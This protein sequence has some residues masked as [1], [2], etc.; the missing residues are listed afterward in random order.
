MSDP[1][2]H[3]PLPKHTPAF[4]CAD[5]GAVSLDPGSICNP[6]G[7]GTKADWCGSSSAGTPKFCQNS[8]NN[9]RFTCA[10]CGQVAVN[11]GLLCQPE[12]MDTPE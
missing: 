6:Q 1:K 7:K 11:P 2:N 12:Q 8:K 10:N 4:I 9:T 3:I 5:C